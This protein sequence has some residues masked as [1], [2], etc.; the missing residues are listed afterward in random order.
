MRNVDTMS[1]L[2]EGG[3]PNELYKLSV[4]INHEQL[5]MLGEKIMNQIWHCRLDHLHQRVVTELANKNSTSSSCKDFV[6]C[7]YC[8]IGKMLALPHKSRNLTYDNL[9]S[10]IFMDI[11]GSAPFIF[12]RGLYY[13]LNFVDAKTNFNWVYQ[14]EWKFQVYDTFIRFK[15]MVEL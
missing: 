2:V 12:S 9:M 7:D 6:N 1:I 10:L 15:K 8:N 3:Q 4:R 5:V 11:W 13:Y 14:L